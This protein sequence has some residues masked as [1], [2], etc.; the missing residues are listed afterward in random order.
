MEPDETAAA[1][2]NA[3]SGIASHFMLD[4]G[5]YTTGA[6]L[7]FGG[8]DFYVGGRAGV[9]G[10]V[11]ADVVAAAFAFFEPGAVRTLW[12]QALGVMAPAETSNRFIACGY[13]WAGS[14]LGDG[15][16][17]S[18]TAELLGTVSAAA[19]PAVAPLFAAWRAM[20]EPDGSDAK[21]LAL[22]RFNVMR[23]LRNAVHAA[24]VVS[25]GLLPVEALLCKTP[26]M[27]GIFGWTGD[28]PEVGD[29]H[30]ALHA[31]AE[32]ATN[33]A[34]APAFGALT[35]AER[36]ELASLCQAAVGAVS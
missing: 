16:D 31:A 14:H 15:V 6:E 10:P 35:D 8:V 18:R 26:Y 22:H 36:T 25:G 34:L 13:E 3:V 28:L 29:D 2:T 32:H 1:T 9:L 24:A 12:D 19:S 33:R 23:E 4:T 21:A 30:Q 11:D 17:W 7:G 20:P 5:T 27:A